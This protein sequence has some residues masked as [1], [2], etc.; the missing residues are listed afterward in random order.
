MIGLELEL[1]QI[2]G[3][4]ECKMTGCMEECKKHLYVTE[5]TRE[6]DAKMLGANERI[7]GC[8]ILGDYCCSLLSP[9]LPPSNCRILH[10]PGIPTNTSTN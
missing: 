6:R 2:R 9:I 7:D 8:S 3:R 5:K 1:E 10:L 4:G